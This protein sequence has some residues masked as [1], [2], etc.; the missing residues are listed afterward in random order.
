M[1]KYVLTFMALCL[2]ACLEAKVILPAFFTDNMV[3][4]QNSML[5]LPGKTKA[6][7]QVTVKTSWDNKKYMAKAATDG[8]F[9]VQIPTPAAGG[10]HKITISDGEKLTL[11]NVMSGEVWFCS[12]Q[13]NMEMPIAGWGK[14]MNYE[15]EIAEADYPSI[16][17]LQVKKTTS[18]TP[19]DNVEM[20]KDGWQTCSPSTIP[21]FS[22]VAYF[23]A[24]QLWKELQ[25]PIGVIDCTWGGTPAEAWTS[26][27]TL[28]QVMG[29]QDEAAKLKRLDFNKEALSAAYQKDMQAWKNRLS[30]QDAGFREG[31]PQWISQL[32]AGKEWKT[33]ELPGYWEGKGLDGLDGI[34]WFQKEI[35]IPVEW[36]GKEITLHLGM[37]DDE[38]ITYYNGKEIAKGA[39]FA[40]PRKY[41]IPGTNVK[42]GKGIVTVRVTDFGGEGGI[43]GNP[44]TLFAE[45]DGRK[46]SL[47][48]QWN[49]RIGVSLDELP[50]A[51]MSPE[52]SSY[53]TVLYNAM[54]HPFTIFP[55]KGVIWYQGEANVGRARQYSPL[56][57]AMIADWRKQWNRNLPFYF[58]QL[59]N[60]LSRQEV[61][62]DSKW[63]ELREAQADALCV[64]NTGMVS[65]IDIGLANDIHPKNKQE[66]GRRLA[67]LALADTY[68]KG[69]YE[70][71]AYCKHRISGN[72]LILSFDHEVKTG[73]GEP[74]GFIIAGPDKVFHPATATIQGK[75]VVLESPEV[76]IPVAARYG[77]ADNPECN[78]YGS[79][80]LP[81]APFR[82]DK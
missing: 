79:S 53:P 3:I 38:D 20:N 5:T 16:R 75:N 33:M 1:N 67:M 62:P 22:A 61:Q 48:G 52:G 13:S 23:Y 82:T 14:V 63:A 29:F 41:Q 19:Q 56:F 46:I 47:A 18:Y 36:E 77:W 68:G 70:V 51:P 71:P 57:Q 80:G 24:R 69:K 2:A 32:Q 35:E 43:H 59:A 28:E 78:V 50:P 34:V 45:V 11:Q 31:T 12:G 15:Q 42:A 25:V 27:G 76:K 40:T 72:K 65:A 49:Y 21:E 81:V 39:G 6:G 17:L 7:K 60:Y 73:K 37:I 4:Q 9:T 26:L 30:T 58:V 55:V 54:V 10:P 66:V 74:K 64:E 44:E 8:S